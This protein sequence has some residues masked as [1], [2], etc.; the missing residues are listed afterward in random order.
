MTISFTPSPAVDRLARTSKRPAL[1]PAPTGAVSLAMG[2]PDFD[3]PE[4]IIQAAETALRSGE[5]HYA[6]QNGLP[7]LRAALA[8]KVAAQGQRDVRADDVLITHG[9]T[10]G[11]AA[12]ILAAVG[13]GDRVVIPEPCYSLYPD[14]VQL[15]GAEPVLVPAAADMHWDLDV[16]RRALAGAALIVFS[17]PCNPTG[18]VHTIDELTTLGAILA[19]TD[20]LVLCDEAYDA[21]VYEPTVFVS[22]LAIDALRDRTIYCQTLSKTYA[23]TGWRLGYLAGPAEVIAA[24]S[25][26]HRTF[27]GSVNTAVQAAACTALTTDP[28]LVENM[29][30][31]Y[32]DRRD[33]LLDQLAAI[34]RLSSY[35][36]DGTFYSF[37]RYDLDR[38]SEQVTAELRAAGLIVRAGAEY[39]PTGEGHIRL[40]FAADKTSIIRAT[41]ILQQYFATAAPDLEPTPS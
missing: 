5:T 17:N 20:T 28:H 26:I 6:D 34:P 31:S 21:I 32:R 4:P 19:G 11:L 3:T 7:R 33:L 10:A 13:P 38:P 14:L 35:A 24:A 39:G 37:V 23:M 2:E 36:I 18:I 41:N 12:A 27:N 30:T 9:A 8:A 1:G 40:S 16:L 29:V 22:A 15:A 25:R